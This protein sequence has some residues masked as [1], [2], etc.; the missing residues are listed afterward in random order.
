MKPI[1][2]RFPELSSTYRLTG[3]SRPSFNDFSDS[4]NSFILHD[5]SEV[6][7]SEGNSQLDID[8]NRT[9]DPTH[10][11]L[12]RFSLLF[13]FFWAKTFKGIQ[14]NFLLPLMKSFND[15]S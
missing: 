5:G 3:L 14:S 12:T 8:P 6:D 4:R 2:G 1:L 9:N 11:L 7:G 15:L 13:F 10:G